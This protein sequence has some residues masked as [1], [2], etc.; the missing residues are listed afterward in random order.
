LKWHAASL[1]TAVA[2]FAACGGDG[3]PT[4]AATDLRIAAWPEG[5]SGMKQEWTLRCGPAGGSLPDAEQACERLAALD[6]R[7]QPPPRDAV[8]TEIYGGPAVAEVTGSYEGT[9]VDATFTRTDGC[10][11][12]RWDRH[13]FLFPVRVGP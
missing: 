5:K 12:A 13:Q 9:P 11:I 8:C 6:D 4:R 1:V 3:E 10:Q 2:L 7:F